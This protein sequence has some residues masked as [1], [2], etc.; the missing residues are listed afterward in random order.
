MS[1][2]VFTLERR[3]RDTWGFNGAVVMGAASMGVLVGSF[4][5]YGIRQ[6]L[7]EEDLKSWGWRIPFLAGVVVSGPGLYLRWHAQESDIDRQIR[8][9]EK[10]ALNPIQRP[11]LAL[12]TVGHCWHVH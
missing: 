7:S 3:P 8:E 11:Y 2:L 10:D 6:S 4:V 12:N 9:Q 5:G 1:S